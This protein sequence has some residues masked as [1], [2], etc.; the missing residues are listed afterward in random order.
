MTRRKVELTWITNQS[1]RRASLRKRRVGLLKKVVEL[2]TLCGIKACLVMYSPGEQEPMAWPS[3]DEAKEL[4]RKFHFI[5]ELERLKK[6]M[7]METYMAEQLSKVHSDLE[8]LNKKNKEAEARQFMLQ[9]HHGKM[10]DDFN[11]HELEELIWFEETRRTAIRKRVEFYRQVPSSLAGPS[12][13]DVPL[14]PSPQGPL[15]PYYDI[16][17]AMAAVGESE[18]IAA[19]SMA[20]DNWF[21]NIMNPNEFR[22]GGSSSIRSYMGLPH[23]NPYDRPRS[24]S[25][26]PH[27]GLPGSSVDGSSSVA[28][29]LGLPG[30]SIGG[31]SIAAVA[32]LG[33]PGPSTG[34][35]SSVVAAELGLSGPSLGRSSR[36]VPNQALPLFPTFSSPMFDAG[37]SEGGYLGPFGGHDMG[38]GHYPLGPVE[39][40]SPPGELNPF[41]FYGSDGSS[42]AATNSEIGPSDDRN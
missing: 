25:A 30:S 22:G 37:L 36:V 16:D 14:Q 40:S 11:V 39:N 38:P 15:I 20:F 28:A 31:S 23:Y 19:T 4:I 8:K 27:L 13:G 3:P 41:G 33:L 17:G 32:D 12:E 1:A 9:L 18:R 26:A 2:T 34:G 10:L 42:S 21:H 29:Q 5:P 7:T 6:T 35:N 24:S